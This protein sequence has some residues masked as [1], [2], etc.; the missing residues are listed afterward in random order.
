MLKGK[1]CLFFFFDS[2]KHIQS[3]WKL[4][5][6][7]MNEQANDDARKHKHVSDTKRLF[8]INWAESNSNS[9]Y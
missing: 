5:N 7:W 3:G 2:Q 4:L 6:E 9:N 8:M 1:D